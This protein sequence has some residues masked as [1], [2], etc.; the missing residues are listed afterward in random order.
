MEHEKPL[1]HLRP[2]GNYEKLLWER[3]RNKELVK[4]IKEL[5]TELDFYKEEL[6]IYKTE[7]KN[8]D[9]GK[10]LLKHKSV[11]N[12]LNTVNEKLKNYKKN[13]NELIQKIVQYQLMNKEQSNTSTK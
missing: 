5:K 7:M 3:S 10:L 8:T 6:K 12:N 4:E 1:I 9:L 13:Q 11:L 2:K